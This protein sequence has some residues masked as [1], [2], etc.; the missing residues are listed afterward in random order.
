M[1]IKG[2]YYAH[3]EIHE[4]TVGNQNHH[5]GLY[6]MAENYNYIFSKALVLDT[7]III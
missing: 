1:L 4:Q 2:V 7:G 6:D 5:N 3:V